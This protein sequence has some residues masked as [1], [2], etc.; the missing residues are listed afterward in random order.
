MQCGALPPLI[1]A[2]ALA[3]SGCCGFVACHPATAVVG[4]VVTEHGVAPQSFRVSL[5]G[6]ILSTNAAGCF[7]SRVADAL[8]FTLVTSSEGFK[9][10]EVEAKRGFYRVKVVLAP[11]GSS[12]SSR[13]EWTAISASE[14]DAASCS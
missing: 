8:P 10:A 1:A 11:V 5:Y 2:S 3:L 14:Y 13:V 9:P 4:N 6:S 12:Q 7:K